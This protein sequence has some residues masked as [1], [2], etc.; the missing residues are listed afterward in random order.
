MTQFPFSQT[1]LASVH[2]H[3]VELPPFD[4]ELTGHDLHV[5]FSM[6]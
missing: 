4:V 5:L 2:V 6:N 3:E 1:A